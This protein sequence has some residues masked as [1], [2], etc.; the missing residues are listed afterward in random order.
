MTTHQK[1]RLTHK[2][3]IAILM[4]GWAMTASAM[5]A[6][7]DSDSLEGITFTPR[8][9]S[10]QE[11]LN[12]DMLEENHLSRF[13]V[14]TPRRH[15]RVEQVAQN[16]SLNTYLDPAQ[17]WQRNSRTTKEVDAITRRRALLNA[18]PTPDM[19]EQ[20]MLASPADSIRKATDRPELHAF[21]TTAANRATE[22][23]ATISKKRSHAA[24]DT[25]TRQVR[26]R[27]APSTKTHSNPLSFKPHYR[28]TTR[29]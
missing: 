29:I 4:T 11:N 12:I 19:Q 8:G 18:T 28:G 5:D 22:D 3:L 27:V 2:S 14:P 9:S 25:T 23:S 21:G 1:Y 17:E 24:A 7:S 6:D 10:P 26:R 13:T 16:F 20:A 15:Q